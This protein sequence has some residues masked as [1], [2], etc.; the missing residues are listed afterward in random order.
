VPFFMI[1]YSSG[2]YLVNSRVVN[3]QADGPWN[4]YEWGVKS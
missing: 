4:A 2:T 1:L 3:F